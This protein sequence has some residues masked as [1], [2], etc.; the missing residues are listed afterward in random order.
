MKQV[1]D[2]KEKQR[3][4]LFG[5]RLKQLRKSKGFTQAYI[6]KE[7]GMTVPAY[8]HY[9]RGNREPPNKC[10]IKLSNIYGV[11]V[12]YLLFGGITETIEE[13]QYEHAVA[14]WKSTGYSV[15]SNGDKVKGNN[16]EVICSEEIFDVCNDHYE[17]PLLKALSFKDKASFIKFTSYAESEFM[18]SI[19]EL[20][21]NIGGQVMRKAYF[22][23]LDK[24]DFWGLPKNLM[25]ENVNFA[26]I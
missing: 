3:R 2:D 7:L 18:K 15:S 1:I 26:S 16:I 11:S 5:E 17:Q 4:R 10:L 13:N 23:T 21:K 6:A 19:D 22:K 14:F 8:M 24:D 9:E 25:N 12:D 20:R